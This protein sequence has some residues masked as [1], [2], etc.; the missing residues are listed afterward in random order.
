MLNLLMKI[1]GVIA[2]I[3][4]LFFLSLWV[5]AWLDSHYADLFQFIRLRGF[6]STGH[7]GLMCGSFALF[8][9][10]IYYWVKNNGGNQD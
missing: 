3:L 8:L 6:E 4:A 5:G 10:G 7:I 9:L 2:V 1:I